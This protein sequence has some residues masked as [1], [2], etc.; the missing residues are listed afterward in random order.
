MNQPRSS[1]RRDFLKTTATLAA[2]A[3]LA[4]RF[5]TAAERLGVNPGRCLVFE[6]SVDAG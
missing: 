5:L 2:G 3:T 6:D 4:P 1:S